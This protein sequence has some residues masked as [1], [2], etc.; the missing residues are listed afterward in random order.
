MST[1]VKPSLWR[2]TKSLVN[3]V[4]NDGA[5]VLNG[6]IPSGLYANPNTNEDFRTYSGE[7][8]EYDSNKAQAEWSQAQSAI[9]DK[10]ELTLLVTD[11]DHGQ[12]SVNICKISFKIIC[13]V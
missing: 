1:F 5:S 7:Y 11:D 9:G 2:L 3:D 10:I 4:L 8:N 12:K 6:L 13:L